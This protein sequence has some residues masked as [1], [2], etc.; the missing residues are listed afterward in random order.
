MKK[1]LTASDKKPQITPTTIDPKK[2]FKLR[3]T[4]PSIYYD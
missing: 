2:A 4:I 1:L 3:K